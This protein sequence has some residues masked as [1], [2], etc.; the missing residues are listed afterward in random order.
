MN[1]KLFALYKYLYTRNDFWE[2]II[3]K[4]LLKAEK[5]EFYFSRWCISVL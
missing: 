4:R 2:K 3:R 1:D 5:G